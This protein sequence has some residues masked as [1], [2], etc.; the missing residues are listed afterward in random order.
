MR[1]AV[2]TS[3]P[4][5]CSRS[6]VSAFSAIAAL[7]AWYCLTIYVDPATT[8]IKV[9]TSRPNPA[10]RHL[11]TELIGLPNPL[12]AGADFTIVMPSAPPWQR[13]CRLRRD[14]AIEDGIPGAIVT[15]SSVVSSPA[16]RRPGKPLDPR[17][18]Y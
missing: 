2:P 1:P 14:A 11:R 12:R 17:L 15:R 4:V 5:P 7:S 10:T 13:Q 3:D 8:A 16:L 6:A 9:S 18:I